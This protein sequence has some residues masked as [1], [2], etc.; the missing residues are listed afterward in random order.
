M[1]PVLFQIGPLTV[2]SYGVMIAAA[3]FVG[4]VI[5]RLEAKRKGFHPDLAYDL[6]L[7]GAIAGLIGAR[8]VFVLGHWRTDFGLNPVSVFYVWQGGLVWYGGFIG[9][10]LGILALVLRRK[11]PV[12]KV[13]DLAAP[14]VALGSAVGRIGCLLNGCCYGVVSRVPWALTFV[15]QTLPRHPTQIY[16]GLYNLAIF[17]VLWSIRKRVKADGMLFWLYVTMYGVGRFTVEIFRENTFFIGP[18]SVSQFLS[19]VLFLV[20]ASVLAVKYFDWLSDSEVRS[21]QAGR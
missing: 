16:D 3:F 9:G 8:V 19:L 18:F 20:G 12:A 10:G 15:G 13:A 14:A 4:F 11:L 1:Y 2:Y 21:G 6:V 17:G 5:A 7:A